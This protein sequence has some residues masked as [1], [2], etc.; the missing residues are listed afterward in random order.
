M[1]GNFATPVT[2]CTFDTQRNRTTIPSAF[3]EDTNT[4]LKKYR[5]NGTDTALMG[6]APLVLPMIPLVMRQTKREK[7]VG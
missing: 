1:V 2:P 6:A 7:K 3:I 4:S 5:T